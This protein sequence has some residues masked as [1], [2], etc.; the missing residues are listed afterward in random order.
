MINESLSQSGVFTMAFFRVSENEF[1][2]GFVIL[3]NE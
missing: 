2:T 1:V 3:E